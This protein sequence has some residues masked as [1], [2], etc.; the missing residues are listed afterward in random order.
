MPPNFRDNYH[1]A[2]S[3]ALS[4][5]QCTYHNKS[6]TLLFPPKSIFKNYTSLY[7][8][9]PTMSN[10]YSSKSSVC[11]IISAHRPHSL[12]IHLLKHT[13]KFAL[14]RFYFL[15]FSQMEQVAI[16][17]SLNSG[18]TNAGHYI[19][20]ARRRQFIFPDRVFEALELVPANYECF[21]AKN[22][23]EC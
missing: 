16:F 12:H 7:Q 18:K 3:I 9:V 8:L 14:F 5:V 1:S 10:V 21:D 19:T 11:I 6:G 4:N 2:F 23:F 17:Y 13:I 20:M 22:A 15:Y